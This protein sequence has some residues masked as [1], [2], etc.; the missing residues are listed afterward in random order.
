MAHILCFLCSVL[1]STFES[2][3]SLQLEI[4]ALRHQISAYRL[5]GQRPWIAP[6]DRLIWSVLAK[7]TVE[8]YKPQSERSPSTTWSTFL[9]LHLKDF[10]AV[11][12]FVVPTVTFKVLF[13]GARS[14]ENRPLQRDG[15]SDR[16]VD[17]PADYRSLSFRYSPA[18]SATR[19]RWHIW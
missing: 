9:D 13:V 18:V 6:L 4:A 11:N 17:S 14:P 7:S 2:R 19:R 10:V 15:A 5:K 3:L 1:T 16:T 12:F 8:K